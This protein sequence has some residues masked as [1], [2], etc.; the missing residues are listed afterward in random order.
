MQTAHYENVK[1]PSRTP[2]PVGQDADARTYL[3]K[4]SKVI[5]KLFFEGPV[6]IDGQVDGEIS[7]NEAVLIGETAVVTG[8]IKAGEVVI[9]GKVSGDVSATKRVE[10]RP[11]ANAFCNLVTPL[12]VVHDGAMFDGHC[13]M[14][15]EAKEARKVTP[16]AR[17]DGRA[18][19]PTS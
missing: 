16:P 18:R 2:G 13:T 4:S 7:L 10:I 15:P 14:N 17:P 19:D 6:R 9:A 5:G 1:P 11:T 12:L 8:Q 3:D